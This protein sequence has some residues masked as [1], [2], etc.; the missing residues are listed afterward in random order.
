MTDKEREAMMRDP[1][2]R[3]FL[4]SGDADRAARL[5]SMSYLLYS[6]ANAYQEDA[7][8][9]MARHGMALSNVR[10]SERQLAQS[11]E[12]YNRFVKSMIAGLD[13]K[14]EL[15][16]DFQMLQDFCDFLLEHQVE[17]KRG[18]YYSAMLYLPKKNTLPDE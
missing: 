12:R 2:V 14:R 9:L 6:L 10:W 15:S 18:P 17:V 5:V 3:R 16:D 8:E 13:E 7:N 11:F 4:A 1:G